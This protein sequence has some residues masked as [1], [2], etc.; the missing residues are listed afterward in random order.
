[1]EV[2]TRATFNAARD[3]DPTAMLQMEKAA[4]EGSKEAGPILLE[5]VRETMA[6]NGSEDFNANFYR[7]AVANPKLHESYLNSNGVKW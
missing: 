5:L 3:G 6:A 1:M 7:V 2:L 4:E